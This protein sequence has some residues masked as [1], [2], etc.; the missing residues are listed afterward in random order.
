M[1]EDYREY[2]EYD[3]DDNFIGWGPKRNYQ[4]PSYPNH[5]INRPLYCMV[6]SFI[7]AISPNYEKYDDDEEESDSIE[8]PLI[9]LK[10][11]KNENFQSE[12]QSETNPE[13]VSV[14][15]AEPVK[16]WSKLVATTAPTPVVKAP[17]VIYNKHNKQPPKSKNQ[18]KYNNYDDDD[19]EPFEFYNRKGQ[20]VYKY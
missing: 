8:P 7:D 3:S 20:T 6:N 19:D 14:K 2:P 18:K 5:N 12:E 4:Y 13:H 17:P 10:P 16:N 15:S 1:E 9:I 11:N